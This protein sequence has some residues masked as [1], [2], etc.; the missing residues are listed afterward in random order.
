MSMHCAASSAIRLY[1]V[2]KR[3]CLIDVSLAEAEGHGFRKPTLLD[4]EYVG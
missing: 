2:T 3:S 4:A 1:S